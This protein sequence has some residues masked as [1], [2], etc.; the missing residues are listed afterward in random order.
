MTR[1]W[2]LI[3]VIAALAVALA[4]VVFQIVTG[5][6]SREKA[7]DSKKTSSPEPSAKPTESLQ[8]NGWWPLHRTGTGHTG[9]R[10]AVLKGHTNWVDGPNGGALGLDG[11]SGF[12]T[13]GS[14]LNTADKDYSVAA[15]VRLTAEG[16]KGFRTAVSQ[17]RDKGS[18]FYLQYSGADQRFAFSFSGARTLAEKTGKPDP[19][20][21]YHLVGTYNQEEKRMTIYVD[22]K[23]AGSRE[24]PNQSGNSGDLVIGRAQQR[25]HPTDYWKG[26]IADV[27]TYQRELTGN[28]VSSL[29]DG[30][31]N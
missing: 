25:G 22:G 15:R 16:L 7:A 29:A 10:D 24:A 3:A 31:P 26:A 13:V 9:E 20:R 6:T 19:D 30:E 23:R 4:F 8:G 5:D 28:E 1:R 21:W 14:A 11:S 27:H 2:S 17:D 18:S 12:A